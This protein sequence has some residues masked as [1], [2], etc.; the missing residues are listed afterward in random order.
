M[1][2]TYSKKLSGVPAERIVIKEIV[3]EKI[4]SKLYAM[5]IAQYILDSECYKWWRMQG[6]MAATEM[7]YKNDDVEFWIDGARYE[8]FLADHPP[9]NGTF[10]QGEASLVFTVDVLFLKD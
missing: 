7:L 8:G 5:R 10:R 2:I 6:N 1:N 9:L 4:L 3:D